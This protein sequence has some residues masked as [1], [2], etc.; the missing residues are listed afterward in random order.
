MT[1][2]NYDQWANQSYWTLKQT[3]SLLL[4]IDP[5]SS[6]S[7]M[8]S[9]LQEKK[10]LKMQKVIEGSIGK[11]LIRWNFNMPSTTDDGHQFLPFDVIDWTKEKKI[12]CPQKLRDAVMENNLPMLS[13]KIAQE[14]ILN[15]K[16]EKKTLTGRNAV[17]ETTNQELTS[18]LE[19]L[20]ALV[21][22]STVSTTP[23]FA[24]LL[25]AHANFRTKFA[26]NSPPKKLEVTDWLINEGA[27]K[28]I[29]SVMDS[30]LRP[31]SARKGGRKKNKQP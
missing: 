10:F 6:D 26:S 1:E 24:L 19:Q 3:T 8:L 2:P 27:T 14:I 31:P 7:D 13:G 22:S 12:P 30:I 18:Q 16:R 9:K 21:P 23:D 5:K 17:L 25:R 15:L 28:R 11:G 4:G 29:A 20:R